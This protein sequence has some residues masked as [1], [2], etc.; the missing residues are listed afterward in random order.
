MDTHIQN[1]ARA[2]ILRTGLTTRVGRFLCHFDPDNDLRF[3]N[4]A[5]PDDGIDPTPAELD[6]LAAVFAARERMPRFEFLPTRSPRLAGTLERH[7]YAVEHRGKLMACD[8]E[9]VLAPPVPAGVSIVDAVDEESWYA[10]AAVQHAAFEDDLPSREVVLSTRRRRVERGGRLAVAI[11]EGAGIVG[12]G[13]IGGP[14]DGITEVAGIAV[15]P[16]FRRRGIASAL[17]AYL[18]RTAIEN[19]VTTCW[20]DPAD[21]GAGAAYARAGY[22][23][24]GEM[25]HMSRE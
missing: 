18:T 21:D 5:I 20:L 10:A 7:G 8:A 1:H 17:T 2:N 24:V 3:L 13:E 14:I 11:A 22:R 15:A 6:E 12:V 25:L 9:H 19:G 16:G 23:V 4:Y